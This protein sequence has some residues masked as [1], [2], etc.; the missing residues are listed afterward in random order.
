M[1]GWVGVPWLGKTTDGKKHSDR[2]VPRPKASSS[3]PTFR[4][5]IGGYG[6]LWCL[7]AVRRINTAWFRPR[8]QDCLH[9]SGERKTLGWVSWRSSRD[10]YLSGPLMGPTR[11]PISGIAPGTSRGRYNVGWSALSRDLR[12]HRVVDAIPG[13]QV[14]GSMSFQDLEWR[15]CP[16]ISGGGY[17]VRCSVSS[18]DLRWRVHLR[19][20]RYLGGADMA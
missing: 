7:L 8:A 2:R 6:G 3:K 16:E 20:P 18:R 5:S 19:V 4:K 14:M 12:R 15:H 13:S 11:R 1:T 10:V 9:E 17:S